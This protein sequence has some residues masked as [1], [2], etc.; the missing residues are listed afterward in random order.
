M[1]SHVEMCFTI[2]A[3]NVGRRA[4]GRY[5]ALPY[6]EFHETK[7]DP[8]VWGNGRK[9]ETGETSEQLMVEARC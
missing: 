8:H 7:L 5:G 3:V 2:H 4:E 6:Q 9:E 1:T